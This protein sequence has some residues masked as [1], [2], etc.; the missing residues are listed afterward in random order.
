MQLVESRPPEYPPL[1]RQARVQG[2]VQLTATIGR[3]G[4]VQQVQVMS[5]HP[6][7]V[8][9]A[10]EAVKQWVYRPTHLNGEAV[11]VVTQVEVPFALP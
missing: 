11:D 8:P 4:R 1:A 3:D 10:I 6:L 7:L 9:A 5:G 2:S